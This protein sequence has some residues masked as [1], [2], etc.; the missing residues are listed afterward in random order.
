MPCMGISEPYSRSSSITDCDEEPRGFCDV[1][2]N[3][4]T[5]HSP[6]TLI[7]SLPSFAAHVTKA[8]TT[9]RSANGREPYNMSLIARSPE[10]RSR[11]LSRKWVGLMRALL[12]TPDISDG[13]ADESGLGSN[14][15]DKNLGTNTISLRKRML[16]AASATSSTQ[17]RHQQMCDSTYPSP[18]A[19][20]AYRGLV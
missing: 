19:R 17:G 18:R 13:A 5:S 3:L 12:A 16:G 10:R 15:I 14:T 2:S 4:R 6:R 9:K 1:H 11:H 20:C 8:P 7:H